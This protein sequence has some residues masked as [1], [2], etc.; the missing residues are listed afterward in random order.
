MPKTSPLTATELTA[1]SCPYCGRQLRDGTEWISAAQQRWGRCGV[2]LTQDRETIAILAM[3]PC[4]QDDE[5]MLK[6]MWVR[7]EWAGHGYGRDL[8]Q[9]A[10]AELL[11]R[12]L[13]VLLAAGGRANLSCA[14]PP[15]DF[16]RETGFH[17][18]VD[19]RL[20]RLELRQAVLERSG[21]GILARLL[22]GLGTGPEP[23]GGAISSQANRQ[24]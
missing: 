19:E 17:R 5:A 15:V 10:A 18:R 1:L 21:L 14:T 12:R 11:R 23:A 6:A 7:P 13:N 20:W 16:L 4:E 8:V 24:P 2:K 3:A 22:R 9:S